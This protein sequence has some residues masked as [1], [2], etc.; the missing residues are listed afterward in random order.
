MK[1]ILYDV[2]KTKN[3]SVVDINFELDTFYKLVQCN[4]IDIVKSKVNG[5]DVEIIVDDE[6]LFVKDPILSCVRKSSEFDKFVPALYGNLLIT[7]PAD[8]EGDLTALSDDV[9]EILVE[10][11]F[12]QVVNPKTRQIHNVLV[13]DQ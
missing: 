9:I 4:T 6:G 3:V 10:Q 2:K 7:G 13:I 11:G 12:I 8:R 1:A 5:I